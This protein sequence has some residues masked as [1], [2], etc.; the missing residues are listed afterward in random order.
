M[1]VTYFI[2][3]CK[4]LSDVEALLELERGYKITKKDIMEF[5]AELLKGDRNDKEYQQKIIDNLVCQVYVRDDN[6][7][8]Y[9][10]I[11]GGK[12]LIYLILTILTKSLKTLNLLECN[13]HCP[14]RKNLIRSRGWV[15]SFIFYCYSSIKGY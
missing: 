7:V 14:A 1:I 10:N 5:V 12:I 13:H 11:K 3:K 2:I 6:T 15:F 8:V 4:H 9:L